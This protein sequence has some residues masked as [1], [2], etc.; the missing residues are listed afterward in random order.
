MKKVV[1]E[2]VNSKN[3]WKILKLEV[4]DNQKD[5]VAT[6][7]E[8]IV[9]AYTTIEAG[10]VALPFGI[11][12]EGVPVGF[13][14]IGYGEVPEEDNPSIAKGNYSIWRFMIDRKYQ[15][16]G[17]AKQAM[18]L[19][20]DYIQ[21]MPCGPAECC[22]LSYEPENTAA[23][24]LYHSFGFEET[25]EYDEDE[26]IAKRILWLRIKEG[27]V[28]AYNLYSKYGFVK[29]GKVH[30]LSEDISELVMVLK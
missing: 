6:N 24:K 25:G 3:V 17:Y 22:F 7:T 11:F 23:A 4:N 5:F 27:N 21:S 8:S 18:K 20:L 16:K 29:S 1:M 19:A 2:K 28:K 14:M 30:K 15:G 9:E 12:A 10:G 26:I 13:I